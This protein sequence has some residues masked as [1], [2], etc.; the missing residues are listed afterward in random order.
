MHGIDLRLLNILSQGRDISNKF[1]SDYKKKFYPQGDGIKKYMDDY[2]RN[3]FTAS[4]LN[5]GQY[6]SEDILR[7]HR[8]YKITNFRS[9]PVIIINIEQAESRSKSG[10]ITAPNSK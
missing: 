9:N 5:S 1:Y 6:G 2:D 8:S 3:N 7:F 10:Q 4:S